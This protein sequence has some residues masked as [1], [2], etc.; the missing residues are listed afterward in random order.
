[1]DQYQNST[2]NSFLMKNASFDDIIKL[3]K[4]SIQ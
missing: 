4:V 3:V 2:I 1:M